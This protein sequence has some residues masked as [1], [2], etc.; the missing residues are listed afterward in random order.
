MVDIITNHYGHC[1]A[2]SDRATITKFKMRSSTC[3]D[4]HITVYLAKSVDGRC[5][6]LNVL[7]MDRT[8]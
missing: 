7:G 8:N 6:V 2:F 3:N 4:V 1:I 5:I